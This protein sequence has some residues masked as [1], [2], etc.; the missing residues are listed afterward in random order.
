V[1]ANLSNAQVKE[2]FEKGF[3][4]KNDNSK[5]EG[6]IRNDDFL[7]KISEICFKTSLTEKKCTIYDT[8]QIKTFQT[9]KGEIFD[10]F[11]IKLDNNA[12]DVTLFAEKI[13]EGETSL[14]KGVYKSAIF[15][16]IAKNNNNYILQEDMF[17]SG[18]TEIKRYNYLGILNL[19]TDNLPI[20]THTEVK[21]SENA[22]I[23]I[24]SKYNTSIGSENKEIR[25]KEKA[26][27]FIIVNVGRGFESEETEYFFQLINRIYYPRFSKNTSLNIGINYYN[28]KYTESNIKNT[29]SLISLPFQLQHNLFNK[30]IRPFVFTGMNINYLRVVNENGNSLIEKSGLQSDFGLSFLLGT[31]IEIDIYKGLMLKGEYR[32]E[33]FTHQIL[34]GIGYNFSK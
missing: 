16:I 6:Y 15:Y 4:I 14:Y 33:T 12:S 30:N 34:F 20:K 24:I 25:L 7:H 31:G 22:F 9:E 17:F 19:A 32:H 2:I 23:D 18:Q 8:S 26:N 1:S 11:K 21:F 27:K 28:Y 5:I 13:L 29:K 3:I 10:L